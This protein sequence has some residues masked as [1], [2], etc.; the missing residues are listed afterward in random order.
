MNLQSLRARKSFNLKL[1]A[2]DVIVFS[3]LVLLSVLEILFRTNV[4]GWQTLV[5]KNIIVLVIFPALLGVQA[6]N[7]GRIQSFS[8]IACYMMLTS[9]IYQQLG[10]LIHML[11]PFWWDGWINAVEFRV[12]RSYPSVW[13]QSFAT[14]WLT[15]LMMFGY[16]IY[17]PLIPAVAILCN[18]RGRAEGLERYLTELVFTYVLCYLCYFLVPVAGP[19]RALQ[20]HHTVALNGYFFTAITNYIIANVHL[21]GGAFPSAHCAAVT[22]MLAALYRHHRPTG[23]AFVALALLIFISTVYGW[24]HYVTDVVSGILF[25]MI[26]LWFAPRL[27][28][29]LGPWNL[30]FE[31]VTQRMPSDSLATE[32]LIE[33]R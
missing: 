10:S 3:F 21:P 7:F 9:F 33:S 29:V 23:Y 25:G 20:A 5:F 11:F 12:F 6:I 2:L 8:R 4:N 32:N 18:Q 28:A 24:F 15:E 1:R 31:F 17:V 16:V 30:R 22:V 19:S 13:C 26:G 27:Q 14:P